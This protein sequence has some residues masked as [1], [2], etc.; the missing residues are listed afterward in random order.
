MNDVGEEI[1]NRTLLSDYRYDKT[2][3]ELHA[4]ILMEA[5]WKL[6]RPYLERPDYSQDVFRPMYH[7]YSP[8]LWPQ[9]CQH[10]Q[11]EGVALQGGESAAR[12]LQNI[13]DKFL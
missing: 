13:L 9:P 5:A 12:P 1:F 3:D 7:P 2:G 6:Q 4:A 10:A 11:A 8:E